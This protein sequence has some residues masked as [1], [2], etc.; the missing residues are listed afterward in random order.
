MHRFLAWVRNSGMELNDVENMLEP[1]YICENHFS[2]N[3]ISNQSRRKMLVHTA[4]PEPHKDMESEN[5]LIS[6]NV[7][8]TSNCITADT[9]ISLEAPDTETEEENELNFKLQKTTRAKN[10]DSQFEEVI[11]E[12]PKPKKR[13][14]YIVLSSKRPLTTETAA[15]LVVKSRAKQKEEVPVEIIDMQEQLNHEA[16][17]EYHEEEQSIWNNDVEI[18]EERSIAVAETTDAAKT[19]ASP[20][21]VDSFSEF[22]FAGEMYVQ[23]PKRV[24][25]A[26]KQKLRNEVEKYKNILKKFKKELD[27]L[28]D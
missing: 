6:K 9:S 3:Y 8:R 18:V 17:M 16:F 25:E 12:Q 5:P 1:R 10:E 28:I 13:L 7:R 24:F 23:M 20:S 27:H 14:Q 11:I 15:K 4:I 19:E 26:E 2:K 21:K 22:I